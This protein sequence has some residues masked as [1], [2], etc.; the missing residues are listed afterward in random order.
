MLLFFFFGKEAF[1]ICSLHIKVIWQFPVYFL[2]GY[3]ERN[4]I[5]M[6]PKVTCVNKCPLTSL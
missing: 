3:L 1:L 5:V 2:S 6:Q 4:I